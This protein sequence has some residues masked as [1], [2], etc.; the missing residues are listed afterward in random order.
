MSDELYDENPELDTPGVDVLAE[1][2]DLSDIDIEIAD[3]I[4]AEE[5]PTI[6]PT[7]AW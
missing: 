1:D 6:E 3:D 4:T 5:L 7:V 2:D